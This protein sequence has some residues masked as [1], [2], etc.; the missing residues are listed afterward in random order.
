M[1]KIAAHLIFPINRPPIKNGCITLQDDGTIVEISENETLTEREGIEFYSGTII[2]GMVNA[3]CH[4]E[5]SHLLGK[6]QPQQG[7]TEFLRRQ[8]TDKQNYTQQDILDAAE[9]ALHKMF[10][11]GV[12]ALGDIANTSLCFALKKKSK[13][14]THTFIECL[15]LIPHKARQI[16]EHLQQTANTATEYQIPYTATLHAAYSVSDEL[17]IQFFDTFSPK[18]LSLHNQEGESE[19]ELFT[20]AGG[21]LK[22]LFERLNFPLPNLD[23]QNSLKQLL[24]NIPHHS[25]TLLVHNTYTTKEDIDYL[26]R[27]QYSNIH[28]VLCPN[29]NY[30]IEK[31]YPDVA[32][33]STSGFP[34]AL[35]T[36]SYASTNSYNILDEMKTLLSEFPQLSFEQV[37]GWAT[38]GGAKALSVEHLYGTIEVG[39][40]PHL[41]LLSPFDF[42]NFTITS[43]TTSKLLC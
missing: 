27:N 4:I 18:I 8:I 1:R 34:V 32:L 25:K 42:R 14:Y 5:Y 7:L 35:G 23:K 13:L 28:W 37:L 39:K 19:T 33:L 16:I 17:K 21:S 9:K 2:P 40:R 6:Y 36:D 26:K 43:A 29:S 15:G 31:K 3:H 24:A 11:D 38:L 12:I 30:F 10:I 20:K 22:E 41:V